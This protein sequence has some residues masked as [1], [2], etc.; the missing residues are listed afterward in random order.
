MILRTLRSR[1]SL[2]HYLHNTTTMLNQWFVDRTKTENM[3]QHTFE[4]DSYWSLSLAYTWLKE[5]G[6]VNQTE[7]TNNFIVTKLKYQHLINGFQFLINNSNLTF[8]FDTVANIFGHIF[9]V[10]I[11]ELN[12]H[13]SSCTCSFFQKKYFCSH[14][15]S[16]AVSIT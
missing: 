15:I 10:T 14:I 8:D 16:V 12:W 7:N 5:N 6:I 4:T 2:S 3:F 13:Y 1:L 11:N 9:Y